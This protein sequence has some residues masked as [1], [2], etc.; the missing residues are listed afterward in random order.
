MKVRQWDDINSKFKNQT[1]LDNIKPESIFDLKFVQVWSKKKGFVRFLVSYGNSSCEVESFFLVAEFK[2]N[3][4]HSG[5]SYHH[6]AMMGPREEIET[7]NLPIW[8]YFN[9]Y[10]KK[11][12]TPK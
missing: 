3:T 2:E 10:P 12:H 5:K 11:E 6:I 1:I 7:L 4:Q 9:Y 8:N